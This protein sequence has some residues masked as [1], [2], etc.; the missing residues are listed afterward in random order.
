MT[1]NLL[2]G[3]GNQRRGWLLLSWLLGLV[4][5][6]PQA[7]QATHIRAGDIQ[8]R[9]DNTSGNFSHLFFRLTIYRDKGGSVLQSLGETYVYFGDKTMLHGSDTDAAGNPLM[10]RTSDPTVSTADT[11]VLYF[12]FDHT[13]PAGGSYVVSFVGENRNEGI[14]NMDRSVSTPFYISTTVTINPAYGANHLPVLRAPA[15]DKGAVGQVFLHNPAA[16]DADGDSL[17]FKLRTCQ[18][19]VGGNSPALL[20]SKLPVPT[21]CINYVFPDDTKIAPGAKQVAYTGVPAGQTMQLLS[22][23][24]LRMDKSP[25]MRQPERALTILLLQWKNGGAQPTAFARLGLSF[26]ICR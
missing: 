23:K 6:T 7:A 4:L 15:V 20:A 8:A 19:V 18:Q 5:L 9:V 16:Y 17:A 24:T 21:D 2:S 26:V 12:D 22:G 10:T 1:Y 3:T 14:I 25:G 13:Y 11:E